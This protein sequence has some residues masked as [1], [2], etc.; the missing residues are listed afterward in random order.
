MFSPQ[1][2]HVTDMSD[3]QSEHV[4]PSPAVQRLSLRIGLVRFPDH[5]PV[6]LV[7]HVRVSDTPT[8]KFPWGAIKDPP[9]LFNSAGHSVQLAYTLRHSL[10]SSKPLSQA[11]F[12]SKLSSRDLSI[13]LE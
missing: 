5:V 12:K 7:G 3:P 10:L 11:L 1:S 4:R 13:T 6:R 8:D 2:R 9:H